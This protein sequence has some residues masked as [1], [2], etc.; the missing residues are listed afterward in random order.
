[1]VISIIKFINN[2][3]CTKIQLIFLRRFGY[4]D[5]IVYIQKVQ[6]ILV[7]I[8]VELIRERQIQK[9]GYYLKILKSLWSLLL[10]IK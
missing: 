2:K 6:V 9:L 4:V 7:L 10:E 3:H 1:M 5:V 8:F